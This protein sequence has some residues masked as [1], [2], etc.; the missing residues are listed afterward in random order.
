MRVDLSGFEPQKQR[1]R[2]TETSTSRLPEREWFLADIIDAEQRVSRKKNEMLVLTLCIRLPEAYAGRVVQD[3][4]IQ[5]MEGHL[6][7]WHSL[8][9]A[10]GLDPSKGAIDFD[11]HDL[12]GYMMGIIVTGYWG[13]KRE[14]VQLGPYA[15][16]TDS[17]VPQ[18]VGGGEEDDAGGGGSVEELPRD[19][20]ELRPEDPQPDPAGDGT[21]P[22]G[23]ETHPVP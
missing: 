5:G 3:Y 1:S 7:R 12:I 10:I 16:H 2:P 22:I 23:P 19:T 9:Q 18:L 21:L 4:L 11:P 14:N 20:P 17:R 15:H 6:W 13:E 8:F